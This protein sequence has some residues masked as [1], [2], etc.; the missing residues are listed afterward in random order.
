MTGS[1]RVTVALSLKEPNN[2]L[3]FGKE[4]FI[5][6]RIYFLVIENSVNFF[7]GECPLIFGWKCVNI[8][9]MYKSA[10]KY[11]NIITKCNDVWFFIKEAPG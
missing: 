11:V 9:T 6:G 8:V 10:Q 2:I 1:A 5:L 3:F 7:E 4:L